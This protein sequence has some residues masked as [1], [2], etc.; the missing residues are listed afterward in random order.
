M[1][2]ILDKK[3]RDISDNTWRPYKTIAPPEPLTDEQLAPQHKNFEQLAGT[4]EGEPTKEAVKDIYLHGVQEGRQIGFEEGYV[5]GGKE[6]TEHFTA[7]RTRKVFGQT[8]QTSP[9]NTEY[10]SEQI[11]ASEDANKDI[12]SVELNEVMAPHAI[13]PQE[14]K[15]DAV[16]DLLRSHFA[17]DIQRT[18]ESR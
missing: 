11:K 3:A 14:V 12:I 5:K 15:L 1:K 6:A 10:T 8:I 17:V 7:A 2:P 16:L 13:L 9:S 4:I 18:G